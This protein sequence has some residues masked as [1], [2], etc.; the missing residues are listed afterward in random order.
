MSNGI[1][2]IVRYRTQTVIEHSA[3]QIQPHHTREFIVAIEDGDAVRVKGGEQFKLGSGDI[4]DLV[5][6]REVS[7]TDIGDDRH[8][9]FDQVGGGAAFPRDGGA[10]FQDRPVQR[11]VDG[12]EFPA[13]LCRGIGVAGKL[14]NAAG[15]AQDMGEHG[16]G[17]RLAIA[18]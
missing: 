15:L 14:V 16:P 12:G 10:D 1:G 18:A 3:G 2:V 7:F 5:I 17:R 8:M 9:G 13:D 4:I 11:R 6:V